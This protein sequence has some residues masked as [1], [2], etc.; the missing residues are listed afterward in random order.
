MLVETGDWLNVFRFA[1]STGGR[2]GHVGRVD[3]HAA[4]RGGGS[5]DADVPVRAAHHTRKDRQQRLEVIA[6][7]RT[8]FERQTIGGR[9]RLRGFERDVVAS[10]LDAHGFGDLGDREIEIEL[11]VPSG[12]NQHRRLHGV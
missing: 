6:P 2:I 7:D 5:L 10:A 3:L 8:N 9:Q 12:G 11:D 1:K 4:L